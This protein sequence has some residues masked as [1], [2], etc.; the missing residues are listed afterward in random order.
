ML[1]E[2][3]WLR[4]IP[5]STDSWKNGNV[6]V[7]RAGCR[8]GVRNPLTV[9]GL[10]YIKN[11][12]IIAVPSLLL[13]YHGTTDSGGGNANLHLLPQAKFVEQ[14]G[15]LAR[16]RYPVIS[17][18]EGVQSQNDSDVNI[19]ITFDDGYR[20]DLENARVLSAN[21]YDAL[22]FVATEYIGQPNYMNR[23]EIKELRQMG[24]GIGSHSHHHTLLAPMSAQQIRQELSQS[25]QIL[26]ELLQ[27]PVLDFSFPGGSYDQ[28]V[29]KIGRELGYHRFFSSDWGVNC[30]KQ[31]ESG[32]WRRSS[33]LNSANIDQFD[34]LLK[35]R[36][37]FTRQ[38]LFSAKEW[39]KRS[40]G[41]DRYVRFRQALINL[42]R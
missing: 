25:K 16:N 3:I 36:H 34:A 37:Y 30:E 20:S 4:L 27:E 8:R 23:K 41:D 15:H 31:V 17:W 14:I 9:S 42:G 33:V 10:S 38:I 1:I 24:M 19:G 2:S 28:R 6:E 29:V 32:V 5:R 26:E 22:F 13:I 7:A 39:A 40:L 21:G 18:R 12:R 11:K 35:R